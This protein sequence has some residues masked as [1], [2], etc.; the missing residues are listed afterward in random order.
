MKLTIEQVEEIRSRHAAGEGRKSLGVEFGVCT[1]TIDQVIWRT[2]KY[3]RPSEQQRFRD[4]IDQT[5]G[6]GTWGDCWEWKVSGSPKGY[7]HFKLDRRNS[8]KA[9]KTVRANRYAWESAFGPI[10]DGMIVRHI[11]DNPRC[12][13]IGHLVIGTQADNLR[14]ARLKGR[15][16]SR[17]D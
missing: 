10:P 8:D 4:Y 16:P 13:R 2:Y 1:G 15:R 12:C 7:G 9:S 17:S 6:Q 11:C 3:Y 14:D 5:P